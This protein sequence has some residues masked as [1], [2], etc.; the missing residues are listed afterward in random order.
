MP[1]KKLMGCWAFVD[2]CLLAAG[3]IT[4]VFSIVWRGSDLLRNLVISN[5]YLTAGLV[6]AIGLLV[7]WA[8]SVGAVIQPNH[9]TVGLAITN[10]LLLVDGIGVFII[11]T[12]IWH[13]SLMQRANFHDIVSKQSN[14][15]I[16]ALQDRL[17]C[18]GYFNSTDLAVVG[19]NF[20]ANSTF[21]EVTNNATGN[22]CVGPI[23]SY[24]DYTLNNVFTS[25]YGYMA[26]II[27]LILLSL[28]VI[29]KRKEGERFRKID[30]KRGGHGFV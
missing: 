20:C 9:V 27:S 13:F 17:K 6:L 10:W 23:T 29:K 22:F 28:C 7:T 5:E 1:S 24:S 14:E 11:G 2:F 30:E 4:L 21:I 26:I 15:T 25:V 19:G 18:C 12:I 16:I 8:A 3:I